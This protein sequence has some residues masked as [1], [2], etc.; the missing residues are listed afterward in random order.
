[1]HPYV[2]AR[3]LRLHLGDFQEP[4][5]GDHHRAGC[6]DAKLG[7]LAEGDVGAVLIPRSSSWTTTLGFFCVTKA[8]LS[9]RQPCNRPATTQPT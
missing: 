6:A 9:A 8:S 3:V 2:E 4:R 5:A 7:E 1:M